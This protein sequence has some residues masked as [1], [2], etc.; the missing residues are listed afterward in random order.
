[1]IIAVSPI[2][3]ARNFNSL[4]DLEQVIAIEL[5]D[6][7]EHIFE[8]LVFLMRMAIS[9]KIMYIRNSIK[10][11]ISKIYMKIL[12]MQEGYLKKSKISIS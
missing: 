3:N 9:I 4:I 10:I 8:R 5:Q 11:I 12:C 6:S 7:E 2:Y 1:M